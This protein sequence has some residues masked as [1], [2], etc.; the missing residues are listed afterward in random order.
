MA[1]E[2]TNS[3]E[4][5]IFKLKD[6]LEK[7]IKWTKSSKQ[8]S[9]VRNESNFNKKGLGSLNITPPFIPHNKYVYVCDNLLCLH[10]GKNRHSKEEC[11]TWRKSHERLSKYTEKQRVL[12]ERPGPTKKFSTKRFS[13]KG[14]DSS[15]KSFVK[16]N[17]KL[18]H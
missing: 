4:R 17:L 2:R 12:K 9:N 10:C 15:Q 13:K 1:L 8:L 3:L 6:E 16:K 5:D 11:T 14:S 18:P 7:Y